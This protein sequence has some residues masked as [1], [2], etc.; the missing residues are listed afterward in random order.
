MEHHWD[1]QKIYIPTL[2]GLRS[3]S[4][5]DSKTKSKLDVYRLRT[6]DDYFPNNSQLSIFTGLNLYEDTK[7][8]LLG[9]KEDRDLITGFETFLSESFFNNKK[10]NII[11]RIDDDVMHVKIDDQERRISE[12]GDGIQSVI[13]LTY[14]LFFNRGKTMKIFME[15]PEHY[16]SQSWIIL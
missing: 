13:I 4:Y 16:L 9:A 2:R 15:E 12:L 11:P 3:V 14:P 6:I 8:L 10:V 1:F 7:K 5:S